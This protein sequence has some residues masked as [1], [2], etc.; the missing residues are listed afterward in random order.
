[1]I[2]YIP[3]PLFIFQEIPSTLHPLQVGSPVNPSGH[4]QT[5]TPQKH[6]NPHQVEWVRN[7]H[8]EYLHQLYHLQQ[9]NLSSYL[10][11]PQFRTNNPH[12]L[13]RHRL[14]LCPQVYRPWWLPSA[15]TSWVHNPDSQ[16]N[17]G[18]L[19]TTMHL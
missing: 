17:N 9:N 2:F 19:I 11:H 16:P 12:P 3:H 8:Q 14:L 18:S 6:S 5:Q 15:Q 10:H 4:R 13:F 7:P 1:M